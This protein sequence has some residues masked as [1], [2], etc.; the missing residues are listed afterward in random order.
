MIGAVFF[1]SRLVTKI[2]YY[3]Q[4]KYGD[5]YF[6]SPDPFE[7]IVPSKR[8]ICTIMYHKY[9]EAEAQDAVTEAS[10]NLPDQRA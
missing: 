3:A 5:L 8:E 6:E 7:P 9:K 1:T 4:E 2:M 10:R